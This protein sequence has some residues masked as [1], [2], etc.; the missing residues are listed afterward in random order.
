[1]LKASNIGQNPS[2]V[3][4]IAAEALWLQLYKT[5]AVVTEREESPILALAD[6]PVV[7]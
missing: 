4:P 7:I 3:L 1:M 6:F 5:V 2:A